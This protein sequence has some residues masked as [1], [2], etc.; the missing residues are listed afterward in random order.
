MTS[1]FETSNHCG[2]VPRLA[3]FTIIGTALCVSTAYAQTPPYALLQYS[4]LTGSGNTITAT[5]VPVVTSKGIV[6]Q[7]VTLLFDVSAIGGLTVAPG[8]PEVVPAPPNLVNSFKA[9][10]YTGP[11]NVYHGDFVINV[12]GPGVTTGGATEWSSATPTGGDYW[13]YPG[14]ATWYGGPIASSPLAARLKAAGIT[15]TQWSYGISSSNWGGNWGTNALIGVSQIGNTITFVS[16]TN[17]NGDHSEPVDSIP[18][19]LAQ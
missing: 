3:V 14:T 19:T 1:S 4:T 17:G 11:G 9:G 8:Y 7:D 15:Q 13:T 5:S 16:F 18:Y 2:R 12:S 10:K 6:Y